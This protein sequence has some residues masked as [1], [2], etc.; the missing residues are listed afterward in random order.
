[1]TLCACVF[2]KKAR[3]DPGEKEEERIAEMDEEA[4]L[5]AAIRNHRQIKPTADP[6]SHRCLFSG[7]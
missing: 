7:S 2:R 3:P 5:A 4:Q 1:M 6:D